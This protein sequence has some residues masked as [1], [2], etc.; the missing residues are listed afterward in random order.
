MATA[1]SP[2][3]GPRT[4]VGVQ[5]TN[6]GSDR[7]SVSPMLDPIE[8]RTGALPKVLLAEAN[9]AKRGCI[10]R[11]ESRGVEALI[12]IPARSR[13]PAQTPIEFA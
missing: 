13:N 8:R 1:G 4:I 12:S 6:V 11:C 7:G 2:L 5:V 3:G 10:E 9:H